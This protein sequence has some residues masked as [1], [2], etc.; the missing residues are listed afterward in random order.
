MKVGEIFESN[1]VKLVCAKGAVDASI[2]IRVIINVWV[3]YVQ[4]QILS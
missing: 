2:R 4:V 3:I 1:G